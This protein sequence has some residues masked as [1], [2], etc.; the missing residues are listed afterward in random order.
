MVASPRSRPDAA[1]ASDSLPAFPSL[2]L[3]AAG[4]ASCALF[5]RHDRLQLLSSH[6]VQ[7]DDLAAWFPDRASLRG[8]RCA[9][10]AA[11]R[12]WNGFAF[13]TAVLAGSGRS[14]PARSSRLPHR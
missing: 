12:P 14:S 1:P 10:V 4:S 11:L 13:P 9:C 2:E 7:L 8:H 5:F 3:T 6:D